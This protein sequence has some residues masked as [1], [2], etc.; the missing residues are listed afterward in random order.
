MLVVTP[1]ENVNQMFHHVCFG[2]SSCVQH[3][4]MFH[5]LVICNPLATVLS[6]AT[7]ITA[8]SSL[9]IFT[10]ATTTRLSQ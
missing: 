3:Q 4:K 10:T 2:L 5:N 1:P 9:T 8:S 7:E 6:R